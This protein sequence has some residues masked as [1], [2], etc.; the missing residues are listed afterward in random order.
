MDLIND[1]PPGNDAAPRGGTRR[2]TKALA[3]RPSPPR[4]RGDRV[5]VRP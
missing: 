5:A 1:F 4:P 2:R 3:G